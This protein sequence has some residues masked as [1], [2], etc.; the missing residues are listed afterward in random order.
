M[1]LA[2]LFS[3][4]TIESLHNGVATHFGATALFSIRPVLLASSQYCRGVDADGQCKRALNKGFHDIRHKLRV[5]FSQ[6]DVLVQIHAP[7]LYV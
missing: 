5:R 3:L 4:K 6:S 7:L 1:M 2:I